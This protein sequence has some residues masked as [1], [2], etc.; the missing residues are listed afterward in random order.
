MMKAPATGTVKYSQE[1]ND[2]SVELK[3]TDITLIDKTI[4]KTLFKASKQIPVVNFYG[5]GIYIDLGFEE[6][7]NPKEIAGVRSIVDLST[8]TEIR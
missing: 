7:V 2:V 5:L 8:R 3:V 4:K 1:T 6:R